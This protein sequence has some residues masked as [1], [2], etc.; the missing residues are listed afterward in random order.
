MNVFA[1][2]E[3]IISTVPEAVALYHKLVPLVSVRADIPDTTREEITKLA[4]VAHSIVA[5]R[6]QAIGTIINGGMAD[7]NKATQSTGSD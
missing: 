7:P 6:R 5:E 1:I 4:D 3:G 2:L